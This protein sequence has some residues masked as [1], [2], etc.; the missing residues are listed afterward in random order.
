MTLSPPPSAQFTG[1]LIGLEN[2]FAFLSSKKSIARVLHSAILLK[3]VTFS[4][5]SISTWCHQSTMVNVL[6][7]LLLLISFLSAAF[8]SA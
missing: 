4:S 1:K 3:S 8:L 5:C 6:C 7:I 2:S